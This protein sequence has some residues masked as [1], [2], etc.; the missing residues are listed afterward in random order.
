MKESP[1]IEQIMVVGPER[2]FVGA[3]IV[4]AFARL[5]EWC[6]QNGIV[7]TS[8]EQLIREPKVLAMYRQEIDSLNANFGHVEQI[9]RFELLPAEWTVE[10]GEM[11]PKLSLRRKVVTEKFAPL[12]EKIY[13]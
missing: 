8:H 9:K 3:L 5:E 13:A 1:F 12:I 6:R 2:K 4:P 11:T 7:V 10:T